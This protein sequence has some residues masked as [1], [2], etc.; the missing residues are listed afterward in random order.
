MCVGSDEPLD[1]SGCWSLDCLVC[2]HQCLEFDVSHNR[3]PVEVSE[4]RGGVRIFGNVEYQACLSILDLF[5]RWRGF[6]IRVCPWEVPL[7]A[8]RQLQCRGFGGRPLP[9]QKLRGRRWSGTL[10]SGGLGWLWE[11][12]SCVM[13]EAAVLTWWGTVS[14]HPKL[15]EKQRFLRYSNRK[16]AAV[17]TCLQCVEQENENTLWHYFK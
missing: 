16:N 2:K 15:E 12:C 17:G 6:I 3:Q 4:Q 5:L 10:G 7:A 8:G 9:V 13:M 14:N 11:H 1:V